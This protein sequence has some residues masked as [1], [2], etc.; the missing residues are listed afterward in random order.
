MTE[1][2]LRSDGDDFIALNQLLK[3]TG[4]VEHGAM[5][6]EVI[7][8]GLVLLNGNKELRKRAKL[9]K[10]DIVSFNNSEVKIS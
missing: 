1:F 3:A 6:N 2:E 10:G 5:A 8:Q 9:R 7:T 4:M